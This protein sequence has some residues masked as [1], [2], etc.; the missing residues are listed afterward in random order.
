MQFTSTK[1]FPVEKMSVDCKFFFTEH[2]YSHTHIK[3]LCWNHVL[4][5]FFP[6]NSVVPFL[7]C[8]RSLSLSVCPSVSLSPP[9]ILSQQPPVLP[10]TSPS[11]VLRAWTS[12][13]KALLPSGQ[14]LR[15]LLV[16]ALASSMPPSP[17]PLHIHPFIFPS[18]CLPGCVFIIISLVLQTFIKTSIS[19]ALIKCQ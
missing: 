17:I 1:L 13:L 18:I 10:T 5:L 6:S 8:L 9:P 19:H 11:S 4:E 15:F 14:V 7:F 12:P 16:C 3:T 2:S